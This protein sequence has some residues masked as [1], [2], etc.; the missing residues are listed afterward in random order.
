VPG[1][2]IRSPHKNARNASAFR[3]ED[4]GLHIIANHPDNLG[5]AGALKGNV[6][7]LGMR[8]LITDAGRIHDVLDVRS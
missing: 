4:V 6:V 1:A 3:T 2:R 5:P 7:D 8:L